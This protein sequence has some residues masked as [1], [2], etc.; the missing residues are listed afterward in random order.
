VHSGAAGCLLLVSSSARKGWSVTYRCWAFLSNIK[1]FSKQECCRCCY[2]L[3]YALSA[4]YGVHAAAPVLE[5]RAAV[6]GMPLAMTSLA[7]MFGTWLPAGQT[8]CDAGGY[9][10]ECYSHTALYCWFGPAGWGSSLPMIAACMD[11]RV[12]HVSGTDG[13]AVMC[14]LIVTGI[15]GRSAYMGAAYTLVRVLCNNTAPAI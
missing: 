8:A 2:C 1:G 7:C 11:L 6:N 9:K 4:S 10:G 13:A 5:A 3:G 15:C 12:M 14:G